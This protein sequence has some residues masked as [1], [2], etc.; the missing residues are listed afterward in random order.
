MCDAV[1]R[2]TY[3]FSRNERRIGKIRTAPNATNNLC[4]SANRIKRYVRGDIGL[5]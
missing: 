2:K 4:G 3:I 5:A 1:F